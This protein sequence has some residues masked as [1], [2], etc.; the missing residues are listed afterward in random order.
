MGKAEDTLR[1]ILGKDR[2]Q[3]N[4]EDKRYSDNFL[5]SIGHMENKHAEGRLSDY[6]RTWDVERLKA[7]C[8]VK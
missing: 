1:Y 8:R 4:E 7:R 5:S 3:F 6:R 2:S